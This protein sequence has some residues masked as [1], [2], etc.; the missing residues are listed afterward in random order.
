MYD[1]VIERKVV[2]HRHPDLVGAVASA[3]KKPSGDGFVWDRR[4]GDV[5]ALVAVTDAAYLAQGRPT[6]APLMAFVV[7]G[8][9]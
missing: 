1:A 5:S 2:V 3:V 9:R 6:G 7:K 4:A 8:K